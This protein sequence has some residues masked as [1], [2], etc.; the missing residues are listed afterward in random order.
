MQV[1]TEYDDAEIEQVLEVTESLNA[2]L[3]AAVVSNDVQF[4]GKVMPQY[5][6]LLYLQYDV[7]GHE[8]NKACKATAKEASIHILLSRSARARGCALSWTYCSWDCMFK[9]ELPI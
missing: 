6:F 7:Q 4:L 3:T 2:H 5:L 8:M 9:A 1:I